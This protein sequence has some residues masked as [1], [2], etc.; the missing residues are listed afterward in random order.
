MEITEIHVLIE[1]RLKAKSRRA[2]F[3][4]INSFCLSLDEIL[5]EKGYGFVTVSGMADGLL[6]TIQ[7]ETRS[8]G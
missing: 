5:K 7:E 1:K 3:Q 6:P 2:Y 8:Y 4:R